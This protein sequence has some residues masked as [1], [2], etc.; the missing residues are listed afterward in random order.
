MRLHFAQAVLFSCA[1]LLSSA[2]AQSS[3]AKTY[4]DHPIKVIVGFVAGGPTDLYAR[5][6]ARA[7]SDTLGQQVVVENK[8]G[9]SGGIAAA[10]VA[11]AAPDGY[12]LLVNVVSDI[13]TPLYKKTGYNLES[14]FAPIGLIA[15]APNVLVVNPDIHVNSVKELIDYARKNPNTITFGSAGTGTVSHLAGALLASET[16]TKMTHVPYKGTNGAQMD[17]LAGRISMMFDNLTNGLANA[18]AGKVNALAITSPQRWNNVPD[19]PTMAESGFP[20]VTIMSIFGLVAP[21][22]TPAP[23]IAKLSDALTK[24]LKNEEYRKSI[25]QS[26][27]EPGAMTPKDYGKYIHDESR[28]WEKFLEKNPDIMKN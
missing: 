27:A 21:A 6:A 24:G 5:I 7:L 26:G 23:V 12:T 25:I 1:T 10:A 3:D 14:N 18:K 11:A 16:G 9:A 20:G 22:G 15:S 8:S 4:P 2:Y 28:R 17:L 13:I 19:V